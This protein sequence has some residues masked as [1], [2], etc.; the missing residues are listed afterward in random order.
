MGWDGMGG[1]GMG[2]DRLRMDG[3]TDGRT[4][5]TDGQTT[6]GWMDRRMD[7]MEGPT[8]RWMMEG[9]DRCR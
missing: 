8:D 5:C 1:D 7:G 4:E 3:R 2:S 9:V 6:D